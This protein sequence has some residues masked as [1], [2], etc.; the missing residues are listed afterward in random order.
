M[1]NKSDYDMYKFFMSWSVIGLFVLGICFMITLNT[2]SNTPF[3]LT[4]TIR[5]FMLFIMV[6]IF[7]GFN[8][9][10]TTKY[11]FIML[12]KHKKESQK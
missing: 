3:Y 12:G 5:A 11:L 7:T 8:I 10:R 9:T 6:L 1:S 4:N 2:A